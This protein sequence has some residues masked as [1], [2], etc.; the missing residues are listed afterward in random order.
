MSKT[1]IDISTYQKNINYNEAIKHID[2]C[3]IRV[4]YG[5][6]YL[7]DSQR[8]KEFDNHYNGFKGRLPIGAYYC[9]YGTSYDTGRKEAENCLAYMGDKTFELPIYYDME[10]NR[11][12]KDAGQGFVDRIREAGL[13]AGI[14]A[15]TSFYKSKGLEDINCDSVWI[16]QY[17]ANTG[18]IPSSKP[19]VFYNIWQYTSKGYVEGIGNDIDMDIT[20]ENAPE[21]QPTPEPSY[22]Y[23]QFVKDIQIA[24]GQTG[25]WIDGIAGSRTLELTPTIS[26][27]K[28]RTDAC[29][30]PVQKYLYYLGYTEVGN[31][32]GIAG[33][34][35][36]KAVKHYQQDNNCYVDGE[37]T[38]HNRTWKKILKIIKKKRFL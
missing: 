5:V 35:F 10:E 1:G 14:Y 8:D 2:F 3:I 30:K 26:R 28:N 37:L 18:E 11:N 12:T 15:S 31:A 32:D 36:E 24:E 29:V 34:K 38:A 27:Y 21:P 25:K 22:S 16:A 4:G 6:S 7:P 19:S 17:G 9:A 20:D 23:T 33:S 13:R